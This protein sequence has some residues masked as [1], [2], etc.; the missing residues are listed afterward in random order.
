MES[1]KNSQTKPIPSDQL[2]SIGDLIKAT[3]LSRHTLH[4]Y[5]KLG[6]ISP[7]KRT[8]SNYRLYAMES[9]VKVLSFIKKSQILNF[10]LDEIKDLL[11]IYHRK[12]KPCKEIKALL[13]NKI[14]KVENAIRELTSQKEFLL[15]VS[16]TWDHVHPDTSKDV[17]CTL[18]D[19]LGAENTQPKMDDIQSKYF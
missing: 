19:N 14:T 3:G 6:L 15:Q 2:G 10:S 9:T 4:Y 13:K 11:S 8:D 18:I 12:R 1:P 17:I 5:E 16:D 7:E